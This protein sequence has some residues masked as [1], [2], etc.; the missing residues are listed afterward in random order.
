MKFFLIIF[1]GVFYM[2]CSGLKL[3]NIEER[4]SIEFSCEKK[5]K[6]KSLQFLEQ[7]YRCTSHR[8]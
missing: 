4:D 3:E 6:P 1:I 5:A 7:Q 2:G 8:E